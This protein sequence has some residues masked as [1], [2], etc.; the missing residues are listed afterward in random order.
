MFGEVQHTIWVS[1]FVVVPGNHLVEVFVQ[2]DTCMNIKYRRVGIMENIRWYNFIFGIT[3]DAFEISLGSFIDSLA[4]II[5]G[6]FFLCFECEVNHRHINCGN[7]KRHSCNFSIQTGDH[8]SKGF[9]CTCWVWNNI[10]SSSSSTSV[11]ASWFDCLVNN[12]LG[13]SSSMDSGHQTW[14]F[15][16]NTLG[17]CE[18]VMNN[19]GKWCQAVG[20]TGGIR[21]NI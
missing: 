18:V 10:A 21:N 6:S 9:G 20:C 11:A 15:S 2:G 1:P 5:I 12:S 4:D 14:I 19:L 8:L 3:E 16:L 7:S 17:N 13:S